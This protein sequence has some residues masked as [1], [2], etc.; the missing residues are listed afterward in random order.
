MY[1]CFV[2]ANA[3]AGSV[4]HYVARSSCT[5]ATINLT[6]SPF[7]RLPPPAPPQ[8]DFLPFDPTIKRTEGTL[9]A[10]DGRTFKCT[11][12]APH[13]ILKLVEVDQEE[14]AKRVNWKVGFR[15]TIRTLMMPVV[16]LL[17]GWQGSLYVCWGCREAQKVG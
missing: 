15:I 8:V 17:W 2:Y 3:S 9:K 16:Q 1:V 12:G 5:V 13:I 7:P 14:V 11:K 10:A 6:I 4:V